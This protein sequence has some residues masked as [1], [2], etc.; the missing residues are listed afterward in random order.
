[1]RRFWPAIFCSLVLIFALTSI[2]STPPSGTLNAP[3]SGA[4]P[5]VAWG[6][7]PYT[8]VTADPAACTTVNC[9]SYTLNVNVPATFYSSNPNYSLQVG[10]NWSSNTN[11][12]DLYV[13]DGSGN[14]VC[15]SGQSMTASEGADCGQLASGTY[16]V[17]VVAFAPGTASYPGTAS[18]G[19]EPV[20]P[21]GKAR[22]KS[23]NVT[24]S[25]PLTL[26]GPP[27][28]AFNLQGIEPRVKTDALGN[29]YAA[30]IQGI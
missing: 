15:S 25:K 1:M 7:G 29:L 30:A 20:S 17:Q 12:F 9:D 19:P 5:G 24:F 8:A 23:G 18:L 4:T 28:V 11:D 2:A 3:A 27:D 26:P 14:V 22:Y 16:T 6:G 13:K 21:V 10:I